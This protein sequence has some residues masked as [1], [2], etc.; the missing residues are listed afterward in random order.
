MMAP[1]RFD[2]ARLPEIDYG[3]HPAYQVRGSRLAAL[4]LFG[5]GVAVAFGRWLIDL[6]HLPK[7]PAGVPRRRW[8][9]RNA[10]RLASTAVRHNLKRLTRST[11]IRS[12]TGS[13]AGIPEALACDGFHSFRLTETDKEQ[14]T[15]LTGP[16]F[17]HL[18]RK[19]AKGVVHFDDNRIWIDEDASPDIYAWFRDM[20][21]RSGVLAASSAWL[22]RQVTVAHLVPQ[23]NTPATDFWTGQFGDVGEPDPACNYCHVD[24]AW[25]ITKVIVY[26]GEVG[27]A[28]GPFSYVRGSHRARDGFWGQLVRKANDYAGL[29]S[30]R[31]SAR[32]LFAALP[33]ALRRKAAFG[34]DL[35]DDHP[36]ASDLLD[37]ETRFTTNWA[38]VILFDPDGVHRGGMVQAGERR[39]VGVLLAEV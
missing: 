18:N 33:A 3:R 2:H 13:G 6:E 22:G 36:M 21:G 15:I 16:W 11:G 32:C 20:L 38:D 30:T 9:V 7:P 27:E 39:V 12:A 28:T 14:I 1:A 24:T 4:I 8:L 26:V 35:R 25:G 19:V 31:P 37:A 5:R 29:S 17:E 23:L 34:P 10:P